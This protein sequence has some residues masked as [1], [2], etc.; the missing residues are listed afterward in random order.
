MELL[1]LFGFNLQQSI[2]LIAVIWQFITASGT[3][4]ESKLFL[5][6]VA[7]FSIGFLS[8]TSMTIVIHLMVMLNHILCVL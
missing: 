4:I 2:E 6:Q 1:V 3:V 7:I 5:R 8:G